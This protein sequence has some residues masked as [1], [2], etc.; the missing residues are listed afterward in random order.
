[1]IKPYLPK[2]EDKR[3]AALQ[4]Y[5]ILDSL[6]E[7]DYD[8]ITKIAS[9]ICD[10]PI[11]LITLVD[12]NRQWFKSRHGLKATETPRDHAFCAHGILNPREPLVV[13]NS[14]LDERFKDNPLVHGAPYVEFYAGIPLVTPEG[15]PLGSLCVIDNKPRDITPEQ[16]DSLKSLANQV[17][18][19]MELRKMVWEL[20]DTQEKLLAANQNLT[21]FSH[22]L[23]HDL[24]A[25]IRNIKMLSQ[26]ILED[27]GQQIETKGQE[28]LRLLARRS[29]DASNM[30]DGIMQYS[31]ST[32]SLKEDQTAVHL[33][34][35]M[36]SLVEELNPPANI[37]IQYPTDLPTIPISPIAIRQIFS[38]LLSNAIKYNDKEKGWIK[39]A[40]Q[41]NKTHYHFQVSDNGKGI[42]QRNL[43]SIFT[44]FYMVDK[45]SAEQKESSGVGLS[46]VKKLIETLGGKIVVQSE[47]QKGTR[48][49]FSIPR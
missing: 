32:H 38:N 8:Q 6:P 23:S 15:Y 46:I 11:S 3:L 42:P 10:T 37:N 22:I 48:F 25:P 31:K 12:Q 18:K 20:K 17:V 49:D 33:S 45:E 43:K 4:A 26:I 5:R 41:Q 35:L 16:I 13:R 47:E 21:E 2:N 28:Y 19:L 14:R 34:T 7:D 44:L 30:I 27:Y 40:F 9:A 36:E 39:V 1:M 24:K 29:G